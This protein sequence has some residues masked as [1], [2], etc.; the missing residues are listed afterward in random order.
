[1][2]WNGSATLPILLPPNAWGLIRS[3]VRTLKNWYLLYVPGLTTERRTGANIA[4][5]SHT[6]LP[7][8]ERFML[9]TLSVIYISGLVKSNVR[10]I[11]SRHS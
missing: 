6:N 3:V 10:G 1:M 2:V 9:H 4:Y 7:W 5:L 8:L 11:Y